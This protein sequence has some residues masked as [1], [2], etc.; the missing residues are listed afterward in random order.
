VRTGDD[1][2][3]TREAAGRL[4]VSL[5]TVR[6]WSEA[7]LLRARNLPID[8]ISAPSGFDALPQMGA[9]RPDLLIVNVAA[10]LTGHTIAGCGGL[11]PGVE[12]RHKPLQ[13]A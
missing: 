7:G 1:A 5:R 6:L 11:P 10:A 2:S 9:S 4:G 8:F 3:S 13:S 12:V